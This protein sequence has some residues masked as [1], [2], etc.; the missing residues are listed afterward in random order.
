MQAL[1]TDAEWLPKPGD[2]TVESR[3][4]T[5]E[6]VDAIRAWRHP[7]LSLVDIPDPEIGPDEVLVRPIAVG[8]SEGDIK[9]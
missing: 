3:M 2:W 6:A 8:I 5:R 4:G 7:R 1:I 9:L